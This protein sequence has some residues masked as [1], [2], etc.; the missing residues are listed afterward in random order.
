MGIR[1]EEEV[2]AEV[3][4]AADPIALFRTWLTEAETQ[5]PNDANAMGLATVDEDGLPDLRVVLL[6]D[7]DEAGFVFYTNFNSAKGQE[8]L[9]SKKAALN[10]HWKSVRRQVRVRGAVSEVT[11]AEAD[12]YFASRPRGA[13]LGAWASNQSHEMESREKLI[14][15]A[16][17]L[18]E[19]YKDADVPRPPHWSGF[20]VAPLEIE[21][22]LDREFRLHDRRIFRREEPG[23]SWTATRIYP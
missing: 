6:K 22:W 10:F 3:F 1:A 13:Q 17:A 11:E 21:F 14:E 8:L 19:K 18:E 16:F 15:D 20:R 5:E 12:A 2:A 7:A 9:A 23:A 4:A